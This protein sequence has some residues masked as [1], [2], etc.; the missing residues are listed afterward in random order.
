[1]LAG[2]IAAALAVVAIAVFGLGDGRTTVSPP[3][4]VAESF[5][6]A[7]E[8]GRFPQ[9]HKYLSSADRPRISAARLAEVTARLQSRIGRIEDVRGEEGWLAG[10]DAEAAAVV[11]TQRSGDVRL[12]LR[13]H[14]EMGEW[15]VV[16]IAALEP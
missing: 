14:R 1:M 8:R 2:M 7:L 13:F 16:G 15:R 3:E 6:R 10:D 4:A 5:V 12:P 9:A 11:K